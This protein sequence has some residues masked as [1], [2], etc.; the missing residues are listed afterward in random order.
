M[1]RKRQTE[2]N[3]RNAAKST[4]PRSVGGKKRAGKNALRHGLSVGIPTSAAIEKQIDELARKIADNIG[5]EIIGEQVRAAA[6]AEFDLA[7][8]RRIKLS[9]IERAMALGYIEP[10]RPHGASMFDFR[11]IVAILDGKVPISR[12]VD[13]DKAMPAQEPE[14]SAEAIRRALPELVKLGRYERRAVGR[15][16]RAL[17]QIIKDRIKL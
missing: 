3:Q 1:A 11:R 5:S 2:A 12:H 6:Q 4:G 14:R 13:D 17:K 8:I 16:D 15:R 9:L 10:R 7:R